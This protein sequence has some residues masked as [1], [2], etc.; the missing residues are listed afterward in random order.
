MYKQG[1][2]TISVAELAEIVWRRKITLCVSV[3]LILTPILFYN[4]FST[5]LYEATATIGFENYSK[6]PIVD[7]ELPRSLSR[8]GFVANRVQEM[9]TATFALQIYQELSESERKLFRFPHPLPPGFKAEK[10]IIDTIMQQLSVRPVNETDFIAITYVSETPNLA[11]KIVNTAANVLQATNLSIRRQEYANLKKFIDEQ[12]LVVSEKLQHAE[13]ALST[14]KTGE[15]ITSI[16]DES[17]EILQRITQAEI[18]FNRIKTDYDASRKKLAM[19]NKK[20]DEQKRDLAGSVVQITDPLI[21]KLKESLVELNVKYSN[22]QTQGLAEDHPKMVELSKEIDQTRQKIVRATM[23]ILEG[24]K[25]KGV[26]DPISQLK[27]NL[28][29]AILLEVEVQSLSAQKANLQK[30]LDRYDERLKELPGQELRLVR[31][32]RDKEVNN[33][34]YVQLLEEREQ[35]RIREAAEIGNIRIIDMAQTPDE[36][37]QPRKLINILIGLFAGAVIGLVAIFAREFMRDAPRT[38]EEA[39]QILARPVLASV[40]YLRHGFSFSLRGN[41]QQR[42][43]INHNAALPMMRDA[44]SY[45]WSSVELALRPNG[46]VLMVTS[47]CA[48]EGKSTVAAN[49]SMIAAQHGKRTILIEGD[50]RNPILYKL[51]EVFPSPGL[52]NLVCEVV[53]ASAEFT[54]YSNATSG[55][56][57]QP[58]AEHSSESRIQSLRQ[59]RYDSFKRALQQPFFSLDALQILTAGDPVN[60]PDRL[61]S[62]PITEE[63]ISS[64]KQ[65][66]DL[67]VID[68][69]PVLGIPDACFIA[70]HTDIVLLCV[71]AT[72]T[73]KRVLQRTQRSLENA[74]AQ[75]LGIVLNKVDPALSYGGYRNYKYFQKQSPAGRAL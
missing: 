11:A 74:H 40:P 24:G 38:E 48:S 54:S 28:E 56:G 46:C 23:E 3:I 42:L 58:A 67:I 36:P 8:V 35:A 13:E 61:W 6:N 27:K 65:A 12:I 44:F 63:I 14:Y 31:L 70:R 53:Q 4:Y 72:K 29:E 7:F 26:M 17:R 21:V 5:P 10:Y 16:D 64:L 59:I 49:L 50:V 22:L 1:N 57:E 18:L 60:E 45:L 15:N 68:S 25:L 69:P 41:H 55:F 62:M 33:K 47:A 43:L 73:Q 32:M 52:T 71:E 37:T 20:L 19:V 9:K 34:T 51:F 39:E 66:A 2:E 30:T 75:V